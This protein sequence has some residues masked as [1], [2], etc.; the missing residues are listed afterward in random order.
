MF[1]EAPRTLLILLMLS[2]LGALRW[3]VPPGPNVILPSLTLG[4][5]LVL[6]LLVLLRSQIATIILSLFLFAE[7][8][9]H[10][11]LVLHTTVTFQNSLFVAPGIIVS[12]ILFSSIWL[13][14]AVYLLFSPTLH[15]F[16]NKTQS[17]RSHNNTK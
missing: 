15:E 7:G 14:T 1:I 17:R 16:H 5:I 8:G 2:A 6:A 10:L 13:G 9:Y 3:L 12:A 4:L 11:F